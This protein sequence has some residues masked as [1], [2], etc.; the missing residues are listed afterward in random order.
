MPKENTEGLQGFVTSNSL[1]SFPIAT[2]VLTI[3]LNLIMY[4]YNAFAGNNMR[5]SILI[6]IALVFSII[7]VGIFLDREEGSKLS[8]YLFVTLLNGI[9][10]FS[11][12]SGV[13]SILDSANNHMD[14]QNKKD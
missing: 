2:V 8:K 12:I 10:L 5:S 9:T 14:L 13:N 1:K 7:Y 11:S 4:F 6:L 3:V